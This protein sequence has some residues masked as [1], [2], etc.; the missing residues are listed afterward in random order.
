MG[1]VTTLLRPMAGRDLT[2]VA[3]LERRAFDDPWSEHALAEELV[4]SDRRYVVAHDR[5][6]AVVGYG[7]L[8]VVGEDAHIM[9]MAVDP[10]HRRRGLGTRLLLWLV[11]A[12]V[13]AGALHLTLE[14]RVSNGA[15]Q[16]LYRRFGFE[17]VGVRPGYYGNEDALIMWAVDIDSDE[18]RQRLAAIREEAG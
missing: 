2:A 3:A 14:V 16:T 4:L 11:D 6:D 13:G 9:T 8:M 12:A 5:H 18:A 7:G 15:A 10:H 1:A 17:P